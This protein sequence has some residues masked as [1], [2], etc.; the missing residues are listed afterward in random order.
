MTE[1]KPIR[2]ILVLDNDRDFISLLQYGFNP[3]GFEILAVN[4]ESDKIHMSN[5]FKA[6]LIFIAVEAPDMLGYSL[7]DK[8]RKKI[9]KYIPIVLTTATLSQDEFSLHS[10]LKEPADAYLD[11]R[12]LSSKE[13]PPEILKLIGL[14]PQVGSFP[15]RDGDSSAQSE[16]S[17][18]ISILKD[19]L[20]KS[21]KLNVTRSKILEAVGTEDHR[22]PAISSHTEVHHDQEINHEANMMNELGPTFSDIRNEVSRAFERLNNKSQDMK[23][24]S[25]LDNALKQKDQNGQV[26][27]EISH[28]AKKIQEDNER[29]LNEKDKLKKFKKE[30]Y[31]FENEI[32]K[33]LKRNKEVAALVE[34][35]EE[36]IE[37]AKKSAEMLTGEKLAHQETRKQLES[38]I[39]QLQAELTGNREQY[40]F[41]LNANEEKF[42]A[43]LFEAKEEQRRV[44][45]D[46]NQTYAAQISQLRIEK[47]AEL[48]ALKEKMSAEMQK[49]A[50]ML[51]DKEKA[52]QESNKQY[53]HKIAYLQAELED[54]QKQQVSQIQAVEEK[55]KADLLGTEERHSGIVDS[56]VKKFA[57]QMAQVLID[58]DNERQTHQKIR[59]DLET[60]IAQLSAQKDTS[61]EK[62][63]PEQKVT[64]DEKEDTNLLTEDE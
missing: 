49:I 41:Q 33:D 32:D 48:K 47:N 52:Y 14:I 34:F 4:P 38:Q 44:L 20:D 59:Q 21:D 18:K 7:Y 46:L 55:H 17:E 61:Q 39:A 8:A 23:S 30:M 58:M 22:K 62:M 1:R 2:Q 63:E 56:I 15:R 10:Q 3:Y 6:E 35:T 36:M 54:T 50:E 19:E 13:I 16:I 57:S 26:G 11:K 24:S 29:A 42:K 60:K 25:P 37:E 40:L 27:R 5:L 43:R 31:D 28:F 53:E 45:E 64:Q 9:S 12:C 51:A